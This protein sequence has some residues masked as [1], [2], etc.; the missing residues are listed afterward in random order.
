MPSTCKSLCLQ[1]V[2]ASCCDL[3]A[4]IWTHVQKP[5]SV[6]KLTFARRSYRPSAGRFTGVSCGSGGPLPSCAADVR[7][8]LV[9]TTT[10]IR[11]RT[12]LFRNSS[13]NSAC[14]CFA[15]DQ[16][17]AE[18]DHRRPDAHI[19]LAKACMLIAL[20]EEAAIEDNLLQNG[21]AEITWLKVLSDDIQHG[22]DYDQELD[23]EMTVINRWRPTSLSTA[24]V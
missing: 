21:R 20:E 1:P 22:S 17:H 14:R 6:R 12:V 5:A 2:Q 19:N 15:R 18:V 16:F 10:M 9:C 23:V 13:S 7:S 4:C 3:M 24:H 8:D 11:H